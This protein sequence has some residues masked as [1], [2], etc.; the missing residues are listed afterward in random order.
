MEGEAR[1]IFI[2]DSVARLMRVSGS[3]PWLP[4]LPRDEGGRR[5][6]LVQGRGQDSLLALPFLGLWRVSR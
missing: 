1:H 6:N 5:E 2:P 3:F 4:D